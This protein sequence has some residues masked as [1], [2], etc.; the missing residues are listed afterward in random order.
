MPNA[1]TKA[2]ATKKTAPAAKAEKKA[3]PKV[4][5][6]TAAKA[7]ADKKAAPVSGRKIAPKD[8][9]PATAAEIREWATANGH[10]VSDRGRLSKDVKDAYTKATGRATA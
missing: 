2:A 9:H 6:K 4:E 5:T 10:E 7:A 8:A 3:A 1:A